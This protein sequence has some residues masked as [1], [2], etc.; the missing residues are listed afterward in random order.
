MMALKTPEAPTTNTTTTA[1]RSGSIPHQPEISDTVRKVVE[2]ARAI[3]TPIPITSSVIKVSLHL[4][5]LLLLLVTF[6]TLSHTLLLPPSCN[7]SYEIPTNNNRN[8]YQNAYGISYW[9]A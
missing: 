7:P 6:I 1:C 8:S 2:E 4:L 5:L 9:R 3:K